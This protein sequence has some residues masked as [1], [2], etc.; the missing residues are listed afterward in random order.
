MYTDIY[1]GYGIEITLDKIPDSGRWPADIGIDKIGELPGPEGTYRSDS[2]DFA[3]REEALKFAPK[4][5]N[6]IIEKRIH[7]DQETPGP[8]PDDQDG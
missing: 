5:A 2:E 6:Q 8:Q 7:K 4:Y 1:K 3:T